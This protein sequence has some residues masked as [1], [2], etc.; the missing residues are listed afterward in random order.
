MFELR[1]IASL[2]DFFIPVANRPQ[3]S[4]HAYR[5]TGINS[6]IQTFL[7]TYQEL[8]QK[9]GLLQ[10]GKFQ[11]PTP[12][13]LGYVQEM[14][15][16]DFQLSFQFFSAKL[17]KWLPRLS[18]QQNKDI[19]TAMEHTF[20]ELRAS[21]KSDSMLGNFYTKIL[22]WM[23][24]RFS[25]LLSR[26]GTTIPKI[27]YQG[28]ISDYELRMIFICAKAG[29][30]VVLLD[31][32]GDQGYQKLDSQNRCSLPYQLTP[33]QPFPPNF[34]L[35]S[36][37]NLGKPKEVTGPLSQLTHERG[38][39]IHLPNQGELTQAFAD[40]LKPSAT[41]GGE[42]GKILTY[43]AYIVGAEDRTTYAPQLFQLFQQLESSARPTA[44]IDSLETPSPTDV[45]NIQRRNYRD[46]QDMIGDF[47]TKITYPQNSKL[48]HHLRKAFVETLLT[49]E[50]LQALPIH[51]QQ[52]KAVYLLC[53][54][55]QYQS[56]LLRNWKETNITC[57]F[58]LQKGKIPE[59]PLFWDWLTRLP[60]DVLILAPNQTAPS[61]SLEKAKLEQY[62]QTL[63]M[64]TFPKGEGQARVGTAAYHAERDLDQL[65]YQDTGMYRNQQFKQATALVLQTMYEEIALLWN[66]EVRFRPNF[67]TTEDKVHIPTL[68]AKVSGVKDGNPT[69]YWQTI[70]QMHTSETLIVS[71]LP[72]LQPQTGASLKSAAVSFYQNGKLKREQIKNHKE[73][74]YGFLREEVQ[75]YIL[76]KLQLM[77]Q[78]KT[79][80]G[81]GVNGTEYQVIAVLL[82]L[83]TEILRMVQAFDFTG[84]NPKLIY[85]HTREGLPPIEDAILLAFLNLLAFDVVI[86]TPTGYQSIEVHF[87]NST[88]GEHQI[89]T[90][91]YDIQIPKLKPTKTGKS[92]LPNWGA[93]L[94]KRGE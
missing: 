74:S 7:S 32:Q 1:P 6:E 5:F 93:K 78:Q 25:Q 43:T 94:F 61:I 55:K 90:Y 66:E 10:I 57:V 71:T 85:L 24:Y 54:V 18:V 70:R 4:I 40:V 11:N 53:W 50:E 68:F 16:T 59:E 12:Q 60:M 8:A 36:L 29:C 42:T 79:I 9:E 87:Q 27:L 45:Q 30:D 49:P 75:N 34:S 28:T 13:Q 22:C 76:D 33:V 80:K 26:I 23:Y 58:C 46:W 82:S 20:Q 62:P 77:L 69:G 83:E 64:E 91:L 14:M 84:K 44:L 41:R 81:M 48:Q 52:T 56:L 92:T 72:Y 67:A 88:L 73:Y 37:K 89:G 35:E 38:G 3:N 15:G 63:I 39:Y 21:G 17:E 2:D 65:L 19:A 47:A 51:K 86:F 31:V